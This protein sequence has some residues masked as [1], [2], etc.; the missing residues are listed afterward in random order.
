M[1]WWGDRRLKLELKSQV[2]AHTQTR[3]AYEQMQR[4]TAVLKQQFDA[5]AV[6]VTQLKA[7]IATL[8]RE[9]AALKAEGRARQHTQAPPPP[10]PGW[11]QQ[12]ANAQQA[13]TNAYHNQQAY[14]NA[15]HY[16]RQQQ[17][18]DPI[19]ELLRQQEAY[20]LAQEE[21]IRREQTRQQAQRAGF[22]KILGPVK[23]LEEAK[24]AFRRLAKAAHPDHGGS[25]ERMATLNQAMA[26]AKRVLA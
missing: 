22:T 11:A 16:A 15:Q 4:D 20:R 25:T 26:E 10:P 14:M 23:T 12:Q 19:A 17:Y 5:A 21:Q 3:M 9:N 8:A 1:W 2:E 24:S 13:Y 7:D 6:V 18:Q